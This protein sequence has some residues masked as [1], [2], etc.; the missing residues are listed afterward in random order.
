M[1]RQQ[2]FTVE[3]LKNL[4]QQTDRSRRRFIKAIISDIDILSNFEPQKMEA[5]QE[6]LPI[7]CRGN[8]LREDSSFTLKNIRN[9][10]L[11]ES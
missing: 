7:A 5:Y 2:L 11:D 9:F 3:T 6:R 4:M 10:A 1:P 8:L